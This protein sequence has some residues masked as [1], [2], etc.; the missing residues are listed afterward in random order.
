MVRPDV[1]VSADVETDGPIP[2]LH[3]LLSFGL[4]VAGVFDGAVFTRREPTADTFYRELRPTGR[5]FEPEALAA[6]GLDRGELVRRGAD[7]ATAM[8]EAAAWVA[9]VCADGRPVLVAYPAVFDFP[10]L[11]RYFVTFTGSCPFGFSGCLDMKTMYAVKAG[12]PVALAVKSRMP[13]TVRP[14]RPHTHHA[15]DD[16]I[17]Q[18]DLFANLMEWEG[19]PPSTASREVDRLA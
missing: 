8:A 9:R 17:E 6:S 4:A 16:A 19:A 11:Y 10:W 3:S 5:S 7:P 18:A 14:S 1:Y 13:A 12:V 15:L 2:G